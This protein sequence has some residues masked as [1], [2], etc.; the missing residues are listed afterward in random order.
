M[1]EAPSYIPT[2]EGEKLNKFAN[3]HWRE[4]L[5]L[6]SQVENR[7]REVNP[8]VNAPFRL[9]K[10]KPSPLG[11]FAEAAFPKKPGETVRG[12]QK[13]EVRKGHYRTALV[14]RAVFSDKEG[15]LYRDV[16]LK[17]TG[18]VKTLSRRVDVLPPGSEH[19]Q[20]GRFGLLDR[21]AAKV[22]YENSEDF[23]R[24]GIRTSRTLAIIELQELLVE[25]K[26][27]SLDK[28][29]KLGVIDR[30]FQ[31][32]VEVRAFGTKAR[33]ANYDES[34][35][36]DAK[37]LVRQELGEERLP[38]DEEYFNWFA[39]TLGKNVALMHKNGWRHGWLTEHN[40]TLDCR[41]VDLDSIEELDSENK[42]LDDCE[43]AKT[44]IWNFSV[45]SPNSHGK[46]SGFRFEREFEKSY[47]AA[48]PPEERA[49]YF[50]RF[51][52]KAA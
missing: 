40:I 17:G 32:V 31:P 48:F 52:R 47:D 19:P 36:A 41:I 34:D 24:A 16:D 39:R 45:N 3:Q 23:V 26:K 30:K 1:P 35:L 51:R 5:A 27:V 13:A 50:A 14:G 15:R 22:D 44:T 8:E 10:G 28:A 33:A 7:V 20:S 12:K 18:Y 43:T 21:K 42:R 6:F 9:E 49:R 46:I 2:G 29:R 4:R 38:T 37:E 11:L 25:G